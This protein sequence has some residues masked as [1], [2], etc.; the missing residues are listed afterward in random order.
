MA[1]VLV[2]DVA[3]EL[4]TDIG[5]V[6][7]PGEVK[8]YAGV[9]APTGFLLCQGQAVSRTTYAALYAVLGNSHG[10]GNGLTTFNL[11]DYRG[12]FLRGVAGGSANDPDRASRTAMST[13]GNTGDAIGSVQGDTIR[14][15]SGATGVHATG[16]ALQNVAGNPFVF[17]GGY[18][19]MFSGVTGNNQ[20][21]GW[22]F[23]ASRQVPTGLDNRP[24]NASVN[25]IIKY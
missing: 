18:T 6:T 17:T 25:F 11:P 5:I 22:V 12:R 7:I 10:S 23:D 9:T 19:S 15:I 13:G 24:K 1:R 8:T 4:S 2:K 14:N 16:A 21:T 20:S 3:T